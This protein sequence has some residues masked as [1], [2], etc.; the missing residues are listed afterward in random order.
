M[1]KEVL[2]H[3]CFNHKNILK[4]YGVKENS[5]YL[6]IIMELVEGGTLKEL[7]CDK[8]YNSEV[9]FHESECSLIIKNILEGLEYINS[10]NIMHRDIKPGKFN[11]F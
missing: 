1:R 9:F 2:I 7:I 10:K 4:L 3:S 8:Y 5:D 11:L 6:F